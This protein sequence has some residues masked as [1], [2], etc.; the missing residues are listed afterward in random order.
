MSHFRTQRE[1]IDIQL[2]HRN[3]RPSWQKYPYL[4]HFLGFL[5]GRIIRLVLEL[6]NGQIF[7]AA[8]VLAGL[9]TISSISTSHIIVVVIQQR[10]PMVQAIVGLVAGLLPPFV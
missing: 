2:N 5:A 10:S 8:T 6:A 3:K 9:G 1:E 4:W 7:S